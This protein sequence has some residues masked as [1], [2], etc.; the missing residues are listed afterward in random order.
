MLSNYL[1]NA[2][3]FTPAG[4]EILVS[5]VPLAQ[6][7]VRFSVADTGPGIPA[8]HLPHLFARFWQARETRH[9]G[10]G[11]G[12]AIANGIAEAHRGRAWAESTTG[13]G[14]IFHLELP[15]SKECP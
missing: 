2:M 4:G 1:N 10:S 15:P 12:L 11:L 13:K 3:K 14:S 7:G 5:A 9:L 6:G 8:E